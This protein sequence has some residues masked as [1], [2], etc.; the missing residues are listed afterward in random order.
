MGDQLENDEFMDGCKDVRVDT[1]S[2]S[3]GMVNGTAEI[4]HHS[5]GT[6]LG[7]LGGCAKGQPIGAPSDAVEGWQPDC[8]DNTLGG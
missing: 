3:E 4:D 8:S 5:D 7:C 1:D 6:P 2:V